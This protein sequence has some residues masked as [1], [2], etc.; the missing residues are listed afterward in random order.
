MSFLLV[1]AAAAAPA[2]LS[3]PAVPPEV[4]TIAEG[5]KLVMR[6]LDGAKPLYTFDK[7]EPG[8]SNC[9]DRCLAAWPA[10]PAKAGAKATGQ[11]T[12]IAR[13]EGASQ[14]A[15]GGKPVYTF[16]RD[17]QGTATGDGMGGVWHLLP[18]VPAK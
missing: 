3:G 11:W 1:I 12:V 9:I 18:S 17:T 8:K 2:A 7:D 15:Y 14:W 5:D 13:P 10:L 16:V 6:S 4:Q